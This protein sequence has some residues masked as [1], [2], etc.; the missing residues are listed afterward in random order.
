[1]PEHQRTGGI[2][3]A[4]VYHGSNNLRVENV[5]VPEIEK[6]EILVKVVSDSICGTEGM[7]LPP[8]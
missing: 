8:S 4:A 7:Y 2:I 3:L 6:G 1:M 5:P